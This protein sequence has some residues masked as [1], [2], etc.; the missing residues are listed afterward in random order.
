MIE[1][2]SLVS[3]CASYDFLLSAVENK[4]QNNTSV[5]FCVCVFFRCRN[6][7]CNNE[8]HGF[9]W[10]WNYWEYKNINGPSDTFQEMCVALEV[11]TS[12]VFL[13]KNILL[14]DFEDTK[15][16]AVVFYQWITMSPKSGGDFYRF[17]GKGWQ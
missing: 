3:L 1:R 12:R 14:C 10:K 9:V 7:V 4:L 8:W 6:S 17:A 13:Y 2:V 15:L 16:A 11:T 5:F